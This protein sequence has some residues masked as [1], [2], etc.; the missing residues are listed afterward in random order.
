MSSQVYTRCR[1]CGARIVW[2]TTKSGKLMPANAE[3]EK[4]LVLNEGV[5]HVADTYLSHFATCPNANEHR[6]EKP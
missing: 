4:R 2:F 3:P 5:A 6:R 1:S